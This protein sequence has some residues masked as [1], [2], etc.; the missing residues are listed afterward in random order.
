MVIGSLVTL[1]GDVFR[2]GH[3]EAGAGPIHDN[4]SITFA[5]RLTGIYTTAVQTESNRLKLINWEQATFLRRKGDSGNDG[6]LIEGRPAVTG[7][8]DDGLVVTAINNDGRLVV[9]KYQVNENGSVDFKGSAGLS[10]APELQVKNSPSIAFARGIAGG[11][12][13]ATAVTLANGFLRADEWSVAGAVPEALDGRT[14]GFECAG[15][16]TISPAVS[17]PQATGDDGY[18]VAVR[19]ANDRLSVSRWI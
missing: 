3:L 17:G 15:S 9:G 13:V 16:P 19:L 14:V 4:P 1:A 6:P 18:Y 5:R 10:L 12:R 7:S 8:P 11:T 2:Q